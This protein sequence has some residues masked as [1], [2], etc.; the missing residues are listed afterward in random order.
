MIE[1]IES[2]DLVATA[3]KAVALL[4]VV[5]ATGTAIFI[6][7]YRES[8]G[9]ALPR[10][11]AV[12]R[13]VAVAATVATLAV[14]S[15]EAGRMA[16]E[17]G[18]VFNVAL[19]SLNWGSGAASVSLV[20]VLGCILICVGLRDGIGLSIAGALWIILSLRPITIYVFLI[21]VA[22]AFIWYF[23]YSR[24]HSHLGRHEVVGLAAEATKP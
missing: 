18:G 24:H 21:W 7:L 3:L 9:A 6:A 11:R 1:P 19:Q 16:G 17:F 23:F 4:C 14:Q 22:V 2:I 15:L 5:Q 13:C 8:S 12:G 20:R 10:I